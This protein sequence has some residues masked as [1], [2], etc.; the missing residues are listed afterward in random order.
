MD[1][2]RSHSLWATLD[3]A[4]ARLNQ[5]LEAGELDGATA[6][7]ER[8][9]DI[10]SYI[11]GM[12]GIPNITVTQGSLDAASQNLAN[13]VAYLPNLEPFFSS[14]YGTLTFDSLAELV[15]PWPQS[16]PAEIAGLRSS[17][18]LVDSAVDAAHRRVISL[19]EKLKAMDAT[20]EEHEAAQLAI[21]ANMVAEVGTRVAEVSRNVETLISTAEAQKGRID[22]AISEISTKASEHEADRDEVWTVRLQDHSDSVA[23]YMARMEGYEARSVKVLEAVGVNSTATDFGQYAMEQRNAANRWRLAAA[24]VFVAAGT[25]FIASSFPWFTA[26]GTDAWES[27]LARLGVTAAVAGVGAYAARESSQHRRE[28]RRSK[29]VQ[30]VLTAL[31]PFIAN[32]PKD[33][34]NRVRTASAEAIFVLRAEPESNGPETG[35]VSLDLLRSLVDKLPRP[36][37]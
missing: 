14:A 25:W 36:T 28:E 31:E 7:V 33:E 23:E 13:L 9:R 2:Y 35:N 1:D 34:Q 19:D 15:A 26:E 4:K 21:A 17:I 18:E 37:T 20:I 16:R 22:T 11:D 8:V 27:A 24:I 30:L 5:H 29:Q 3:D 32:L 10:L 12:R 6:R